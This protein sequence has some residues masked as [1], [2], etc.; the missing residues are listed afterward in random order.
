[1][2]NQGILVGKRGTGKTLFCVQFAKFLGTRDLQWWVERTDGTT[3]LKRMNLSSSSTVSESTIHH[4]RYIQS[5]SLGFRRKSKWTQL[6]LTDT[7]GLYDGMTNDLESRLAMAQTLQA[8]VAAQ[9]LFHMIDAERVAKNQTLGK[10]SSSELFQSVDAELAAFGRARKNYIILANKM[11]LPG[12]RR[13]Y[14]LL[15][16]AFPK[17]RVIPISALTGIG[18]REVKR[19]VRQLA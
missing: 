11:D 1:M 12:G 4:T 9:T 8:M 18:F 13:G 3:E 14:H 19:Y 6:I 7:A 10:T 15:K 17:Q 16:H 5:I 2:R